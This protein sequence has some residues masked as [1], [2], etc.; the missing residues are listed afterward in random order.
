MTN[1]AETLVSS[2][3]NP[4]VRLARSLVERRRVRYREHAFLAEG[5][6]V[7]AT[8]RDAGLRLRLVFIDAERRA[9]VDEATLARLADGA[10]R[11][12]V[13]QPDL[14]QQLTAPL[15]PDPLRRRRTK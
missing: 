5:E 7:L 11:I 14:Y 8:L 15:L 13:V 4:S 1:A 9:D 2:T 10:E 12:L 6:R 3:A